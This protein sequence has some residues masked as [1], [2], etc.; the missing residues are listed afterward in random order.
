M[1]SNKKEVFLI[2]EELP[3]FYIALQSKCLVK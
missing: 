3:F 2:D 1:N